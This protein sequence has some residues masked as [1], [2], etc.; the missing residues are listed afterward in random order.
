[1]FAKFIGLQSKVERS[2]VDG[3]PIE[4]L[5]PPQRQEPDISFQI[6]AANR[7]RQ[8]PLTRARKQVK[9]NEPS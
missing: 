2:S 7:Q 4:M 5:L 8:V 1:M 6:K 9:T 3:S